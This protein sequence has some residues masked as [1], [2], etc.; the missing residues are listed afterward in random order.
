VASSK[1]GKP[2]AKR[3]RMT[4]SSS[5]EKNPRS[6]LLLLKEKCGSSLFY[7]SWA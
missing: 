4:P 7:L 5:V 3:N 1:G 2:E 6:V